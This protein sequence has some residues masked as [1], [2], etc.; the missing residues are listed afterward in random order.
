MLH[1]VCGEDT[2]LRFHTAELYGRPV[3]FVVVAW[4]PGGGMCSGLLVEVE[5]NGNEGAFR[6]SNRL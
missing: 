1:V 5:Y 4:F 6:F 3:G 2:T